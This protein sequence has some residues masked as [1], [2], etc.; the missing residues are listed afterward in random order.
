MYFVGDEI[1]Y[2]VRND[3]IDG[4]IESRLRGFEATHKG[5]SCTDGVKREFWRL[6]VDL[7][8]EVRR[9][10]A[11]INGTLANTESDRHVSL[12]V[13]IDRGDGVLEPEEVAFRYSLILDYLVA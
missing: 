12:E 13:F 8:S 11:I 5:K 6:R 10:V 1:R 7:L 2:V 9:E 3:D 4:I